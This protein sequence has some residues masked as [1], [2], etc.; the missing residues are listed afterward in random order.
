MSDLNISEQVKALR[1]RKGLSQ[2]RL[3]KAA[4]VVN[5]TVRHIELGA[6]PSVANLRKVLNVLGYDLR[7][8]RISKPKPASRLK[9]S[10]AA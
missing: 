3:A 6:N 1:E 10:E 2:N 9:A 8:V 4:G 7:I 5:N